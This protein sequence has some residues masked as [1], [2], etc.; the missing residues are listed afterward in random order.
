MPSGTVE[1][2]ALDF[3]ADPVQGVVSVLLCHVI[4]SPDGKILT[5][6]RDVET[7]LFQHPTTVSS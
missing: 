7:A 2:T 6:L 1:L 4:P 3:R 5:V